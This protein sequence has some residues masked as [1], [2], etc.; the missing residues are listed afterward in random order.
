MAR[1]TKAEALETRNLILDT[2]EQ[3]F[4]KQGVSHTSLNDIAAAAGVTRGAIYGHFR[5]KVDL[6]NQMHERIHTPIQA[7]AD[8]SANPDE[9]DPLG[10]LRNLLVTVLQHTVSDPHQQRVLDVLFL[11][12]EQIECM[13]PIIELHNQYYRDGVARTQRTLENAIRRGQ[14]PSQLDT[15]TASLAVH[16]WIR[17]LLTNWL[18]APDLFDLEAQ[19]EQL[20]DGFLD[21]LK[22]STAFLK[23]DDGV[24]AVQNQP[25]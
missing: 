24:P 5:N 13:G 25:G 15:R 9:P 18:F 8:E 14:L 21:S 16:A 7:L 2:A 17:G 23:R 3:V 4:R 20:V 10:Q 22:L 11:R 12:C 6:F 1:K 19:A